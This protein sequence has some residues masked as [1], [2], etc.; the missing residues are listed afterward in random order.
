MADTDPSRRGHG[1]GLPI[2][3]SIV[4]VHGGDLRLTPNP[5]GGLISHVSLPGGHDHRTP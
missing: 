2:V 3:A 5:G 1:L 4:G